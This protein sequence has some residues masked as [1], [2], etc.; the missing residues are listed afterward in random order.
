MYSNLNFYVMRTSGEI[1]EICKQAL[2]EY[3]NTPEEERSLTKLGSKYNVKRQTLSER[4]KKWGYEI[5]NQQNRCRLNEKAFDSMTSEEQFY[6]LG[7]MYADGNISHEGN[8]IE[9]RL[10]IKDKDHLEKFRKFLNLTTEIRTGICDG[11]AFCHLS[12]RNKHMWDTLNNL[13]CTP[14]KTLTLQFPQLSLFKSRENIFHFIRG[15]V[16]RDGCLTTYLNSEK[17]SIRTEL[18]LVGT[19]SFL[20]SINTLF[21]NIGYIKNKSSKGWDNKAF[22]LSFSDVPSRKIARCLYENATLYLNR[23]YEKFLE[24]CRIEEESSKRQSSKI[25]EPWDGNTEITSKIT[26]G[27]EVL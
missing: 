22:S 10:S 18:N 3:L 24:F 9:V 21:N 11:N 20:T 13:G 1:D 23:K 16:D 26:K 4:F 6:W 7:F 8:R 12:V 19:E 5:V 2:K 27:L 25:G 17:K 14:K 15:Y